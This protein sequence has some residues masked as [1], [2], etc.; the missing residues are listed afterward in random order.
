MVEDPE[1]LLLAKAVDS[2]VWVCLRNAWN[3][4]DA[5]GA[6]DKW[7][8]QAHKLEQKFKTQH[9]RFHFQVLDPSWQMTY[10]T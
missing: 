7:F 4:R 6:G 10:T 3:E 9:G 8:L 5:P 2:A 1:V